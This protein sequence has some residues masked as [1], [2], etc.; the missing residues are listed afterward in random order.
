MLN[1]SAASSDNSLTPNIPSF[2]HEKQNLELKISK[3]NLK[4][5]SFNF[6]LPSTALI[7]GA[8]GVG[9]HPT[10]RKGTG[11]VPG[12]GKCLG[13]GQVPGWGLARKGRGPIFLII[14]FQRD[15]PQGLEKNI[16]GL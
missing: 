14:T 4:G 5:E 9:Q 8:Q 15:A 11:S 3:L 16:P 7:G 6:N 10:N 12:Q 13:C 1:S 2:V